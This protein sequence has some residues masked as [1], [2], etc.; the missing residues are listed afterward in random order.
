MGQGSATEAERLCA[1]A[2]EGYSVAPLATDR[3][4]SG[5]GSTESCRVGFTGAVWLGLLQTPRYGR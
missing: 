3:C 1:T 4:I 2:I 5:Q